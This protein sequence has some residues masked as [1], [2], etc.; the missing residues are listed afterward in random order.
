MLFRSA[1]IEAVNMGMRFLH[2][3]LM[4]DPMAIETVYISVITFASQ[5]KHETPLTE[6]IDFVP[7]VLQVGGTT[8]FG[9]ALTL[10]DQILKDDIIINM[11][12]QKG[13]YKPIVFLMT[14]GMPTDRWEAPADKIKQKIAQ[15]E[16]GIIALGCGG[17]VKTDVLKRISNIVLMMHEITPEKIGEYFKWV[18]QSISTASVSV[19]EMGGVQM[20]LDELPSGIVVVLD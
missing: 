15:K 16:V 10:L 5:A 4:N 3:E 17:D 18:S 9:K 2:D 1:P 6:L 20:P 12:F 14:D 7:P 19:Q 11:P 13:D 8:S